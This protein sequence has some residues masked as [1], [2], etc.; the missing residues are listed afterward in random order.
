VP[1]GGVVGGVDGAV[2][3]VLV[4]PVAG[5]VVG[6]PGSVLPVQFRPLR[7]N[8]AGAGLL[9]VQLPLKPNDAL[10]FV[11]SE[12]FQPA[13]ETVT[14]SPEEANEAFQPWVTRCPAGKVQ[15]TC[16]LV[17]GSPRFFTATLAVKPPGH[18]LPAV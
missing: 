1:V 3:G 9:P 11:A 7:V 16:Q 14:L 6:V 18:W 4:G 12:P 15:P 2:V 17:R 8:V 5:G 10:P 13:L